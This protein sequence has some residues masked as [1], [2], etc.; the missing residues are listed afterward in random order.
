VDIFK[1]LLIVLGLLSAQLTGAAESPNYWQIEDGMTQSHQAD[2]GMRIVGN[3]GSSW[4]IARG[5][6]S[7]SDIPQGGPYRVV[8]PMDVYGISDSRYWP[9]LVIQLVPRPA[10]PA[11]KIDG[12][13]FNSYVWQ[14]GQ[15]ELATPAVEGDVAQIVVLVSKRTTAPVYIDVCIGKP[16]VELLPKSGPQQR[17]ARQLVGRQRTLEPVA[18][19][20]GSVLGDVYFARLVADKETACNR[21]ATR[22]LTSPGEDARYRADLLEDA[23]FLLVRTGRARF[24]SCSKQQIAALSNLV[25]RSRIIDLPEAHVLRALSLADSWLYP[26]LSEV[27]RNGIGLMAVN[28]IDRI[29]SAEVSGSAWW[30]G[31]YGSNYKHAFTSALGIA[32]ERFE[33]PGA[34]ECRQYTRGELRRSLEAM[35]PDGSSVEGVSYWNYSL[36][37]L[38]GYLRVLPGDARNT[39][40]ADSKFLKNATMFRLHMSVPGFRSVI[41]YGDA[42]QTEH[43]RAG[44]AL[45]GLYA[46]DKDPIAAELAALVT[47]ARWPDVDFV[48][49][50]DAWEAP[51]PQAS[52]VKSLDTFNV[53]A[54]QG[55]V[56]WRQ[57]W[58]GSDSELVFF[59]AGVPQGRHLRARGVV[60]GGHNHPDQGEILYYGRGRWILAD[61][62]FSKNKLTS[63][64]NTGLFNG[65]GQIGEGGE[66]FSLNDISPMSGASLVIRQLDNSVIDVAAELSGVYPASARLRTWSRRIVKKASAPLQVWDELEAVS[67]INALLLFHSDYEVALRGNTGCAGGH[68]LFDVIESSGR[69]SGATLHAGPSSK[70]YKVMLRLAPGEPAKTGLVISPAANGCEFSGGT[71]AAGDRTYAR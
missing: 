54:D 32:C 13:I 57:S 68:W 41:P 21:S 39:L 52:T 50:D 23:A 47:N 16:R 3:P 56:V 8:V 1:A 45:R 36:V 2:C 5:V 4:N 61:D 66:R 42:D 69:P 7:G 70:V 38:V 40:S 33:F 27:E 67:N 58:L 44:T 59:K 62:G 35:P 24:L 51:V 29:R 49:R 18:V 37:W 25:D 22:A 26:M 71:S 15:Q 17:P 10:G 31:E 53:F 60:F 9:Q 43:N 6:L 34:D 64:H 11:R 46:L 55:M 19:R 28:L 65:R 30:S 20:K 63:Q 12:S 14:E 48:W